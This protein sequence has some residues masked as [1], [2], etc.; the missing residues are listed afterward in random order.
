MVISHVLS[1]IFYIGKLDT[2]DGCT[3]QKERKKCFAWSRIYTNIITH[4]FL[5]AATAAK[6]FKM[7][8]LKYCNN[9]FA[10][11]NFVIIAIQIICFFQCLPAIYAHIFVYLRIIIKIL[12]AP[13]RIF[14]FDCFFFVLQ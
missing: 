8:A 2:M 3:A 7:R 14:F 13:T 11:M 4:M 12:H 1:Y 5:C 9:F 10:V 6:Q